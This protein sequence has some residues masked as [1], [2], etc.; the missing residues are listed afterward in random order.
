MQ[1]ETAIRKLRKIIGKE[2]G[3]RINERALGADAR[4]EAQC[5]L[6]LASKERVRLVALIDERLKVVLA[7]DAEYQAIKAR[8]AEAKKRESELAAKAYGRKIAVGVVSGLF[9]SVRAQGDSWEEVIRKLS[10]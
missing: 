3:Y 5:E 10:K 7:A 2:F 8:L 4:A 9:F 1:R 6:N